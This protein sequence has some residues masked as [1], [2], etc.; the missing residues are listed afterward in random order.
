MDKS[1][2]P[3]VVIGAGPIGLA[4]AAHLIERGE[5]PVVVEAGSEVGHTIRQ[6]GHVS[7]F[8]PWEYN[9]DQAAAK[10][11]TATGWTLPE[12]D[13]I[14]TGG[15]LVER[16]LRPLA[17]VPEMRDRI[18]FGSKVVGV[19][20]KHFDKVRT[21]GRADEPF[22]IRVRKSD[23]TEQI[24]EAKAVIDAS[25]T[26]GSPNPAG[27]DGLPAL[28]EIRARDHIA[29]GIPDVLG[30]DIER[31]RGRM[32][33]VVG[34][35][36]SALNALIDLARLKGED[37]AAHII[38]VMRKANIEAA[39]GGEEADGLQARGALGSTARHLVESGLVQVYSPFRIE[40]IDQTEK[41]L[42]VSGDHSGSNREIRV[43][44][45]IVATGFRPDLGFL[46]EIRLTI[47]PWLESSGQIGPLIDPNLHSCGTVRPHGAKE[48]SHEE[49]DFYIAGMKSYGRAPTFLLATGHEQVRSIVA[50]IV[51]DHE[52]ARR[53]E[54][55]LPETGVCSA[56]PKLSADLKVADTAS[57]CG[58]P[59]KTMIPVAVSSSADGCCGTPSPAPVSKCC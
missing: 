31:Y 26:W 29:Y 43:D 1:G 7:M 45:M 3:V 27:S 16:Y 40:R 46:R 51:G 20:R 57:C 14:P 17:A 37:A 24:I 42:V 19:T 58:T 8:S 15:E 9:I 59:I 41:G 2:L 56:T 5:A 11:L 48:L 39:Y 30:K 53:V 23:G 6:W 54:L 34:G 33:M 44:E 25:G 32:V 12:K 21:T 47:D 18:R 10:L 13:E 4:A 52:A 28:G 49:P 36:H 38:W 22:V 35:G 50:E 55:V